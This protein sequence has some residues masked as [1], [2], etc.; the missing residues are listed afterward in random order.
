MR[1]PLPA[2][3]HHAVESRIL[4]APRSSGELL[5]EQRQLGGGRDPRRL[6]FLQAL[7][8]P[9]EADGLY[10]RRGC[11]RHPVEIGMRQSPGMGELDEILPSCMNGVG[12]L[13][14]RGLFVGMDTRR[15]RRSLPAR[16][17]LRRLRDDEPGAGPGGVM[18]NSHLRGNRAF[19]AIARHRGH[20][21]AVGKRKCADE[22][23]SKSFICRP[24]PCGQQGRPSVPEARWNA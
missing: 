20:H 21:D 15:A 18:D 1:K 19:G 12:D 23:G 14:M 16:R 5:H 10:C 22:R 11:R 4:R 2:V 8:G 13:A 7:G 17:H 9:D 6:V 24:V 3:D